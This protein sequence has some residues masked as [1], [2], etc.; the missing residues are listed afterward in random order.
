MK[1]V[2]KLTILISIVSTIILFNEKNIF[3][4]TQTNNK[5]SSKITSRTPANENTVSIDFLSDESK[6]TLLEFLQANNASLNEQDAKNVNSILKNIESIYS[7]KNKEISLDKL[8]I[9]QN[10]KPNHL[11]YLF[12]CE[13][14]LQTLVDL[15]LKNNKLVLS[16]IRFRHGKDKKN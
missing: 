2:I 15:K 6:K 5:K 12:Q 14:S 7:C 11:Q 9:K 10:S 13:K 3:A 4:K 1:K 8:P 16:N